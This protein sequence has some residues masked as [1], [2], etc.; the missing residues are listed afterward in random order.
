[1]NSQSMSAFFKDHLQAPLTNVQWSWGSENEKG[2]YLRIWQDEVEGREALLYLCNGDTRVGQQERSRH[3]EAIK[4][5]KPAY[6]VLIT[7]WQEDAK[8]K[9]HIDAYKECVY[10]VTSLLFRENGDVY[11]DINFN[12]PRYPECI[13]D[14][15]DTAGIE[16]AVAKNVK[17]FETM[18][19]AR[20]KF[21]WRPTRI[22]ECGEQV[23][24]ISKDGSKNAKMVIETGQW[25]R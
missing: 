25:I 5:G 4:H 2:I 12:N 13:G 24:F 11:A 22:S 7:Q 23:L 15:I 17:A 6:V 14:E 21:G 19:K 1:M 9:R 3:I 18:Q 20:E 16:A 8:G 10:P